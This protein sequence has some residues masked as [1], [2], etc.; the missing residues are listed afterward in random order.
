TL[1]G[2]QMS[3]PDPPPYGSSGTAYA[4][5]PAGSFTYTLRNG[6]TV[7]ATASVAVQARPSAAPTTLSRLIA[8]IS[9]DRYGSLFDD[10]TGEAYFTRTLTGSAAATAPLKSLLAFAHMTDLHIVDDQSPMRVPYLDHLALTRKDL[11]TFH[12]QREPW[13]TNSAYFPHEVLTSQF[14]DA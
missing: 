1:N 11:D 9:F 3:R 4:T 12:L 10:S 2:V 6:S 8:R 14:A 13:P 7:L 5:P